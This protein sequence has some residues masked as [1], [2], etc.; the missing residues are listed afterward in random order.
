MKIIDNLSKN[1]SVSIEQ[2]K[3]NIAMIAELSQLIRLEK[4][5]FHYINNKFKINKAAESTSLEI[6][7]IK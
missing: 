2:S 1:I 5:L 6:S 7:Q 4:K 3:Q